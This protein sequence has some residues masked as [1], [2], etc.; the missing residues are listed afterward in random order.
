MFYLRIPLI[1]P[2]QQFVT[3]H[4]EALQN[5]AL[6]L[7]GPP[8]ARMTGRIIEDLNTTPVVTRRMRRELDKLHALLTLKH[9][10]DQ[11][12]PEAAYFAAIDPEWSAVDEICLL[13]EQLGDLLAKFPIV[14]VR[15]PAVA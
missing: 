5:A 8:A 15:V 13:S 10:H 2:L 4:S 11:S 12:R 9:V 1:N 7:G 6:L 3:T 14:A